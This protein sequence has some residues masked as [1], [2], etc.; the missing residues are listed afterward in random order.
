MEFVPVTSPT[1][2]S[3]DMLVAFAT[4]QDR[5]VT[6][7]G[8]VTGADAANE[9]MTGRDCER[10]GLDRKSQAKTAMNAA[11]GRRSRVHATRLLFRDSS[12]A[13]MGEF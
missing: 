2:W 13:E 1:P 3:I 6:V 12:P 5:L 9:V 11:I 10:R 8:F 7:P 4:D